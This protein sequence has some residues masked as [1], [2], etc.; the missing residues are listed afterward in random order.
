MKISFRIRIKI[1]GDFSEDYDSMM[2]KSGIDSR[3]GFEDFGIQSDGTPVIFDKCGNFGY[4]S[5]EF[6]M[7]VMGVMSDT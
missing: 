2:D 4:L 5:D 3:M 1:T 7:V 6:E